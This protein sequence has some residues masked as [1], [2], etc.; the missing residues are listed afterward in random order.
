MSALHLI[1]I[2][3]G[4][5][6]TI[7]GFSG[8]AIGLAGRQFAESFL[9]GLMMYTNSPF[10]KGELIK[11]KVGGIDVQGTVVDIGVFRT[12]V[13]SS[14]REIFT[15]P[16]A[17]IFSSVVLN[18]SRR[19]AE[20]RMN[21]SVCLRPVNDLMDISSI[22]QVV[23]AMRECV[24][25]HPFVISTLPQRIH[26]SEIKLEGYIVTIT[27]Y[28]KARDMTAFFDNRESL[29]EEFIKIC[30]EKGTQ[31]VVKEVDIS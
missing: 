15:V 9:A 30:A 22:T 20:W 18:K 24:R 19:Y 28:I 8:I 10:D 16:N 23:A 12:C 26:L 13:R 7:G 5:L 6:I 31:V 3:I 29:L 21:H 27:C 14:D 11:F 4:N 25:Q 2:D 17:S 1:G